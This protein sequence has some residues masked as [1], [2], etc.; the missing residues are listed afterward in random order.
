MWVTRYTIGAI[1]WD[2]NPTYEWG[3]WVLQIDDF[4]VRLYHPVKNDST[5][6][7]TVQRRLFQLLKYTGLKLVLGTEGHHTRQLV[8]GKMRNVYCFEIH[9]VLDVVPCNFEV[10]TRY[11]KTH[12]PEGQVLQKQKEIETS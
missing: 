7:S 2:Y 12:K 4:G 9:R 8:R 3:D 11:T 6:R 10:T 1:V 5:K